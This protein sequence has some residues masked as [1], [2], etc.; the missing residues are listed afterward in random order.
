VQSSSNLVDWIPAAIVPNTNGTALF[1]DP[2]AMNYSGRF[3][4]AVSP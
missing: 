4:R 1:R 3:Y 2:A